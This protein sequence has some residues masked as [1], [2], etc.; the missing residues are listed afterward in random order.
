MAD[1]QQFNA[2]QLAFWNGQGGYIW[3]ARQDHTDAVLAP[4]TRA[5]LE[6]A[7]PRPGE[8]VLDIGCGCG[9]STLEVARAVGWEGHVAALDIS[10]SMLAEGKARASRAGIAHIDWIEA[11]AATATL[12]PF[13]LLVSNCGVMF[14]G[15]PVAAFANLRRHAARGARMV[16]VCWRPLTENPWMGVPMQA[17]APLLPP[18][19][20]G[21]PRAPGMFAFSDP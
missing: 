21:D 6:R 2:D 14:F 10:A 8:K 19:P 18:R 4:V 3:V 15:D 5:L 12:A 7:A 9:G 17:V 20:K 13:D 16:F 1:P 11:D